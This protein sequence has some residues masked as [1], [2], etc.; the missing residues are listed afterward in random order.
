MPPRKI[1]GIRDRI[2]GG[3][4]IGR[5]GK[6][7]GAP[8]L[9]KFTADAQGGVGGGGGGGSARVRNVAVEM[10]AGSV[11]RALEIIGQIIAPMAFTLPSGLAGSYAKAVVASTGTVVLT[12]RKNGSSIGT[13]TFTAS[14]TGV[15]S[16]TADVAFVAGDLLSITVPNPPDATLA[17]TTILLWGTV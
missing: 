11:M 13:I 9:I 2:P 4:V 7:Y 14:A 17:D 12:I 10:F 1:R 8:T 6:G 5:T 3:Y 15:F 16:F